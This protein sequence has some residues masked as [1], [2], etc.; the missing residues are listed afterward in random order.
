MGSI[1]TKTMVHHRPPAS[2]R[3]TLV[4]QTRRTG[5]LTPSPRPTQGQIPNTAKV[6][7]LFL[8]YA[9]ED[10]ERVRWLAAA[11]RRPGIEVWMDDELKLA[12]RFNDEIQERIATCDLFLPLL[13]KAT[14]MGDAKRF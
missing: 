7:K 6:L 1:W 2:A 8:S 4:N 3:A 11:L 10:V 5:E 12:G 9:S 13:S 14:Q